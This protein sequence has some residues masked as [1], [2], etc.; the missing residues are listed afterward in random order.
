MH[1]SVKVIEDKRPSIVNTL[2]SYIKQGFKYQ[3]KN[4]LNCGGNQESFSHC[5]IFH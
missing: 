1:L 5:K 2:L 4:P 3:Y